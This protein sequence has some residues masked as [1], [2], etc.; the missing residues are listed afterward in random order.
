M[1]LLFMQCVNEWKQTIL[2]FVFHKKKKQ[3]DVHF[4]RVCPVI[5]HEFCYNI[6]SK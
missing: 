4:L 2:Q 1:N 6:A 3:I 5:D